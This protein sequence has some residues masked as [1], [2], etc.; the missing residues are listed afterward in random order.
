MIYTNHL[1]YLKLLDCLLLAL[2][3]VESRSPLILDSLSLDPSLVRSPSKHQMNQ[4]TG[5]DAFYFINTY[6]RLQT[7]GGRSTGKSTAGA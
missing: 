2:A 1:T 5:L 6:M 3:P 4:M 7:A